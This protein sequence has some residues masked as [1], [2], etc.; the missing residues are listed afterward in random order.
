MTDRPSLTFFLVTCSSRSKDSSRITELLTVP[1]LLTSR[2]ICLGL[3]KYGYRSLV[4]PGSP[5]VTDLSNPKEGVCTVCIPVGR[6]G[7]EY[8]LVCMQ[9][10]AGSCAD[11]VTAE[12]WEKL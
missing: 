12:C 9:A 2:I 6:V 4:C 7:G 10:V 5:F 8:A 3:Q 1:V 11:H